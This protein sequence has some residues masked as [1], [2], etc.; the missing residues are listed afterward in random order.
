[1]AGS[2]SERPVIAIPLLDTLIHSPTAAVIFQ[3]PEV[4]VHGRSTRVAE[5][6][7]PVF[8]WR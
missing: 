4:A 8:A 3:L 7:Q 1:M 2:I 6:E 5:Y